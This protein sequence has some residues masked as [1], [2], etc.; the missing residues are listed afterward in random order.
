MKLT[1]WENETFESF[2]CKTKNQISYIIPLLS[3]FLCISFHASNQH[4]HEPHH[5]WVQCGFMVTRENVFAGSAYKIL[6]VVRHWIPRTPNMCARIMKLRS[7]SKCFGLRLTFGTNT[8]FIIIKHIAY[9]STDF[10]YQAQIDI[11]CL[12]SDSTEVCFLRFHCK[13]V[14]AVPVQAA[15][16]IN[17]GPVNSH[18]TYRYASTSVVLILYS[19]A[20]LSKRDW[21][22]GMDKQS[23]Q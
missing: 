16:W 20:R 3:S 19:F 15:T 13:L 22:W 2:E 9:P 10:R 4:K 7:G 1:K 8:S 14:S 12:D 23:H 11:C 6:L 5:E 21:A 18:R 17:D